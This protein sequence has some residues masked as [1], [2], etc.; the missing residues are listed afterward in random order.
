MHICSTLAQ[1][2]GCDYTSDLSWS[3]HFFS[4]CVCVSAAFSLLTLDGICW[5]DNDQSTFVTS[6]PAKTYL[7][8]RVIVEWKVKG[9]GATHVLVLERLKIEH[10]SA[11]GLFLLHLRV[12]SCEAI[13]AGKTEDRVTHAR[14]SCKMANMSARQCSEQLWAYMLH[15]L[16]SCLHKH[17]EHLCVCLP[18]FKNR[19]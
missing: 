1:Y 6:S 16:A 9:A 2:R 3:R 15:W 19:S 7:S 12:C 18:R 13:C 10:R 14:H 11:A 5:I 17:T 4:W 8:K